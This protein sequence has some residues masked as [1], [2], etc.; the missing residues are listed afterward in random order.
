MRLTQ[1]DVDQLKEIID[2]HK[3]N[4]CFEPVFIYYKMRLDGAFQYCALPLP[5]GLEPKFLKRVDFAKNEIASRSSCDSVL[6]K[7]KT[8]MEED[9]DLVQFDETDEEYQKLSQ[10]YKDQL[11]IFPSQLGADLKKAYSETFHVQLEESPQTQAKHIT[12]LKA[13]ATEAAN[14]TYRGD[15]KVVT[16]IDLQT[17]S[18]SFNS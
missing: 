12:L 17:P 8:L 7:F 3:E 6:N 9:P 11:F 4:R 5:L 2:T 14:A 1:A 15:R 10:K 16:A 18:T 13:K